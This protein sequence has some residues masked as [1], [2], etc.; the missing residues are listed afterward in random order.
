MKVL[1][2]AIYYLF[3]L[4]ILAISLLL[5]I[6]F[7]PIGGMKIKVV[8]S[9]SMEPTIKTGSVVLIKPFQNY[10]VGD[11]ITFGP[12]TK[13]QVPTTHRIVRVE[14]QTGRVFFVTK[15]D[16]NDSEDPVSIKKGDV[17]GKVILSIPFAGFVLDFAKKPLGFGLL[18]G[19]PALSIILDEILNII[20]E[21]KRMRRS[22]LNENIKLND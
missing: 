1:F 5:L 9:G 3:V 16:A 7:V 6:S 19:V 11:V 10:V 2:S 14:E 20:N 18:V 15:G 13:T 17:I 21:V 4:A 22:K 8:Q 12:D